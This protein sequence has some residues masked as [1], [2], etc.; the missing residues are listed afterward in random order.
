MKKRFKAGCPLQFRSICKRNASA[1][2]TN[3]LV[4]KAR[5]GQNIVLGLVAGCAFWQ[6]S[7]PEL[8][9]MSNLSGAMFFMCI[10]TFM[11]P[12]MMTNLTF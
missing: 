10:A 2:K 12:Y 11:A 4:F 5:I 1:I 7:G 8:K 9:D 3:P 6:S